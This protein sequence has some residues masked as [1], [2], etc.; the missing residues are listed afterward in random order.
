[1][2]AHPTTGVP[3]PAG[4]PCP[5]CGEAPLLHDD[6]SGRCTE[7]SLTASQPDP[8]RELAEWLASRAWMLPA[9]DRHDVVAE[10]LIQAITRAREALGRSPGGVR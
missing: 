6:P 7:Q 9:L 10:H 1:M 4:I 5:G 2:S 3:D 8:L